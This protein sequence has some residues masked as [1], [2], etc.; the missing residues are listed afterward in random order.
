MKLHVYTNPSGTVAIKHDS[1]VSQMKYVEK[2]ESKIDY[3]HPVIRLKF[4]R[5]DFSELTSFNHSAQLFTPGY[6]RA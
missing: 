5:T 4:K 3:N 1:K 2:S 6:A